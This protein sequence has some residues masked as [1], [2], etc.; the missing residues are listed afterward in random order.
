MDFA[1]YDVGYRH[2]I[3]DK[4]NGKEARYDRSYIE[5]DIDVAGYFDAY[6]AC[7]VRI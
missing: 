2:G 4:C 5:T 7:E 1:D 3:F 6:D